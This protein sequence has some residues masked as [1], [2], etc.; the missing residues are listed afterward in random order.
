M[1]SKI[2][3]L[4]LMCVFSTIIFSQEKIEDLPREK[5]KALGKWEVIPSLTAKVEKK[6][7]RKKGFTKR[8]KNSSKPVLNLEKEDEALVVYNK[9]RKSSG[10]IN[11]TL[12]INFKDKGDEKDLIKDFPIKKIR[13]EKKIKFGIYKVKAGNDIEQVVEN[14]KKDPRIKSVEVEVLSSNGGLVP[15]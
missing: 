3:I 8:V 1:I 11:G 6:N 14:L 15:Q 2:F 5:I 13:L 7:K 10:T 9:D 4:I 12:I